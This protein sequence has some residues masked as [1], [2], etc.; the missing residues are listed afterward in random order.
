MKKLFIIIIGIFF[1]FISCAKKVEVATVG[2]K[3]IFKSQV[4]E[5]FNE[6]NS[7]AI[8][9]LGENEV[10]KRILDS[11][12][13]KE[14]ILKELRD[15]K[16]H[17]KKEVV[18]DWNQME[19][20]IKIRYFIKRYVKNEVDLPEEELKKTYEDKKD[21]FK[22]KE[23]V[24]A[25]HILLKTGEKD[26]T[27]KE[28]KKIAQ[29]ILKKMEEDG[30]LENFKKLAKEYSEGPTAEKSGNL[31]YFTRGRMVESFENA[32]FSLDPGTFTKN[33]IKTR[34]GYHIIYVEDH[35]KEGYKNFNE[36]KDSLFI[37]TYK[38]LMK[39]KYKMKLN[40][41]DITTVEDESTILGTIE[42]LGIKYQYKDLKNDLENVVQKKY[43][44]RIIK[45][46]T[47]ITNAIEQLLMRKIYEKE[48]D[49]I[50]LSE[51]KEYQK[52]LQDK[53]DEFFANYYVENHIF[54][55]I[56]VTEQEIDQFY[57]YIKNS[58]KYDMDKVSKEQTK[59]SI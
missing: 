9:N 29:D 2:E 24:K 53:K 32:A 18:D 15:K 39:N 59:N 33:P 26:H 23:K 41:I 12:I 16:I 19:E 38:R 22:Q 52:Y 47:A 54:S 13:A 34:F 55:D 37:D 50:N 43:I 1:I 27:D 42:K 21:L 46:K 4:E 56:T 11:L 51:N 35:Q 44:D 7:Q 8:E 49:E 28:A 58:N 17:Q 14:L 10:K 57:N 6:V 40:N 20:N 30:S 25:S 45:N 3:R 31:G 48:I 36:V 5:K